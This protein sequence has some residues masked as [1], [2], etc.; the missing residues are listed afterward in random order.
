[1]SMWFRCSCRVA[2]CACSS[3]SLRSFSAESSLFCVRSCAM[4]TS[5]RLT[6]F[7]SSESLWSGSDRIFSC[8]SAPSSC[9]LN[10][11]LASCALSTSRSSRDCMAWCSRSRLSVEPTRLSWSCWSFCSSSSRRCNRDTLP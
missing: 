5:L 1:M 10:R 7:F 3:M 6:S 8:A 4:R 9:S 11:R 2:L